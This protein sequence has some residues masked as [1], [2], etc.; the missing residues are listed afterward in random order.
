MTEKILTAR[1]MRLKAGATPTVEV[2]LEE[3]PLFKACQR[4][5]AESTGK[6]PWS[7]AFRSA[8]G[9]DEIGT[10]Q[11]VDVPVE[12]DTPSAIINRV[13]DALDEQG[14]LAM[15]VSEW[16]STTEGCDALRICWD[17]AVIAWQA[18]LSLVDGEIIA[19]PCNGCDTPNSWECE[20]CR[21]RKVF[22]ALAK[23]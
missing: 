15:W 1:E 6:N 4:H 12:K 21:K 3:L 13:C 18:G 11:F 22:Q 7:C 5:L 10:N 17:A 16:D 19:N 23:G 9:L 8:G 2:P 14:F 20:D